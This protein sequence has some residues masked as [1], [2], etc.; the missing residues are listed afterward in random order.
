[1]AKRK[2]KG[3]TMLEKLAIEENAAMRESSMQMLPSS[4]P[5]QQRQ[6]RSSNTLSQ[7]VH[8]PQSRSKQQLVHVDKW[9]HHPSLDPPIS[10]SISNMLDSKN[11]GFSYLSFI[12]YII[13]M[14]L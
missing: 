7:V 11:E 10:Q 13:C 5:V 9:L 8:Q 3:T 6:L 1:M 2:G 14:L 12:I 4:P